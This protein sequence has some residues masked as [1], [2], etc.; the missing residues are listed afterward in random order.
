MPR[1][2]KRNERTFTVLGRPQ[3]K[4]RPR[5][6]HGKAFTPKPT[7]DYERHIR[8]SYIEIHGD[9]EPFT[10]IDLSVDVTVYFNRKNHGD[11]DNY[12]KVLDGLNK[13]AWY[14]DKQIKEL[15]GL[16]IVDKEEQERMEI[17]IRPIQKPKRS[18][19]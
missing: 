17:S 19:R 15:Y 9:K 1:R 6:S 2:P 3:A 14:D 4:Q 10:D 16:L 13:V 7:R 12:L 5:L 8:E 18:G 11:L